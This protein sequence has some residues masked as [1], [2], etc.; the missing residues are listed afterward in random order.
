MHFP[1][2]TSIRFPLFRSADYAADSALGN[3]KDRFFS[4]TTLHRTELAL[5][6]RSK[7][8][9]EKLANVHQEHGAG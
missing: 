9:L 2:T 1:R 8:I 6:L 3:C 4:H 5:G 7:S